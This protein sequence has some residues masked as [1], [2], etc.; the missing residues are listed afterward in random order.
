MSMPQDQ[1]KFIQYFQR[2]N[3]LNRIK[4]KFGKEAA[5]NIKQMTKIKLKRKIIEEAN[6]IN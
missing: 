5:E 4:E 3:F 6:A 1:E 2:P